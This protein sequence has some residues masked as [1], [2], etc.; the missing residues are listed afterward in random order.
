MQIEVQLT[1]N[2]TAGGEGTHI[3]RSRIIYHTQHLC[4]ITALSNSAQHFTTFPLNRWAFRIIFSFAGN[5]CNPTS[6][7]QTSRK[8]TGPRVNLLFVTAAP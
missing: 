1:G 6:P 5:T 8:T 3:P 2:S 4:T 7:R